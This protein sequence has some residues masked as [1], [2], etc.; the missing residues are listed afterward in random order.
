M[1]SILPRD[2]LLIFRGTTL[3]PILPDRLY[4]LGD[5]V[6]TGTGGSLRLLAY[7]HEVMSGE[8]YEA[9]QDKDANTLYLIYEE[10]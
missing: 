9:L 7:R 1:F 3:V 10:D 2:G 4:L 5:A 6:Y 8:A